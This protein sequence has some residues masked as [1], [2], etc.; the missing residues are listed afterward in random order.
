MHI[1]RAGLLLFCL[2]HWTACLWFLVDDRLGS[3][4]PESWITYNELD[5]EG[6]GVRY[7][8]TLYLVINIVSS[9]GY[10]DMFATNDLERMMV[11]FMINLGDCLF[12]V[13]FGLIA[14]ISLNMTN[15]SEPQ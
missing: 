3:A 2:S 14:G 8:K 4:Y 5:R 7:M 1:I 15:N 12:A 9:V 6:L 11:V 10:G 13:A